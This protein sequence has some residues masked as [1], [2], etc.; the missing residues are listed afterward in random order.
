MRL[1][2]DFE[3]PYQREG[4]VWPREIRSRL[5]DSIINGFDVPK[6][7]F[8]RA[9]VRRRTAEGRTVQYAILDGKQRLESIGE[10]LDDGLALPRDFEFYEDPQVRAGGLTYEQLR[11]A[12]PG[13]AQ[14]VD[15][16]ELPIVVVST[17][18]EELIEE[19]FARL[20]ASTALNNA[21][22]RKAISGVT[23]DAVNDLAPHVLLA[24]RSPIKGTRF[25]HR[26]LVEKFLAIE[27]QI[28]RHGRILDTKA[29]TLMA[30]AQ[31]GHGPNPAIDAAEMNVLRDRVAVVLDS[32]A[33]LFENNDKNLRSVGTLVVYYIAFRDPAVMSVATREQLERFED[34]RRDAAR[35]SEDDP[36]YDARPANAR[37]REYNTYVQ[38]SNDGRALSRRAAILTAYITAS[39]ADELAALDTMGDD[40]DP[41]TELAEDA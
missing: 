12:Y 13:L 17:D 2:L 31:A 24:E 5:I 11:S 41:S 18:S 30:L 22:R 6:L 1:V 34:L 9:T 19:M 25:K 21:E 10:F 28:Q 7:Y 33:D 23:R 14:R 37:L 4:S 20:N 8:E 39:A 35:L 26:E 38:S 15:D 36:T 27:N 16:Y 29:A 32:M 40:E 3:P